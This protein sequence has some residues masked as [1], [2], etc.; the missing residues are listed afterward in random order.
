[1]GLAALKSL[2][3]GHVALAYP[4]VVGRAGSDPEHLLKMALAPQTEGC[5]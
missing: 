3:Y 4:E 5:P 1:V 2:R